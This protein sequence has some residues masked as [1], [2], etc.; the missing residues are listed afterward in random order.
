MT[1]FVEKVEA[2]RGYVEN[3]ETEPCL[4]TLK[5]TS[6]SRRWC[7]YGRSLKDFSQDGLNVIQLDLFET[8]LLSDLGMMSKAILETMGK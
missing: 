4:S 6:L 1:S 7:K 8:L 5:I 3:P 2:G